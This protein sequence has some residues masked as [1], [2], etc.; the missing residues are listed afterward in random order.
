MTEYHKLVRDKIPEYII[1][2]GGTPITHIADEKEY[3]Q[4]LLEKLSEE[5][6]EF[7]EDESPEEFADILEV[8][9]AIAVYKHFNLEEIDNMRKKKLKERGGFKKRIILDES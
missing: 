7:K 6:N 2:K 4:K 5:I 1:S 3:W 9:Y 8:I